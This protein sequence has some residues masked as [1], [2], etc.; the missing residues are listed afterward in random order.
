MSYMIP[1]LYLQ[2][3][4]KYEHQ[5]QLQQHVKMIKQHATTYNRASKLIK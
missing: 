1:S 2:I 5:A 4:E 3:S